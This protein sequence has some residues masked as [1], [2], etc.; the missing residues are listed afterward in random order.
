MRAFIAMIAIGCIVALGGCSLNPAIDAAANTT[1]NRQ[2][3][4]TLVDTTR[5]VQDLAT[6][7]INGCVATKSRTGVCAPVIIT[8]LHADLAASRPPRDQLLA[9]ALAHPSDQKLGIGGLYDAVI[10]AKD[11]ITGILQANNVVGS[12]GL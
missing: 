12:A 1:V 6:S 10:A 8:Q 5:T 3:V 2:D 9:F 4:L 7:V 11:A